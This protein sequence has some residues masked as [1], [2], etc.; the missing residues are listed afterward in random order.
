MKKIFKELAEYANYIA[1]MFLLTAILFYLAS[2]LL[3]VSVMWFS[4]FTSG[5]SIA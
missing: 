1:L 4:L 3:K 2:M 5:M